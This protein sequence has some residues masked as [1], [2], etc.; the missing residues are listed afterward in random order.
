MGP[1]AGRRKEVLKR[2]E[3]GEG[4][5]WREIVGVRDE[6]LGERRGEEENEEENE[7][8]GRERGQGSGEGEGAKGDER[9]EGAIVGFTSSF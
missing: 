7:E 6:E 5:G 8:E 1:G 4:R 9:K 3:V 2:D